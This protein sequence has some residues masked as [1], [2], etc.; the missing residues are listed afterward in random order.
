MSSAKYCPFCLGNQ[1]VLLTNVCSLCWGFNSAS[2]QIASRRQSW[3]KVY[4]FLSV[5]CNNH[6]KGIVFGISWSRKLARLLFFEYMK[7]YLFGSS[8][9]GWVHPN[10]E[11]IFKFKHKKSTAECIFL[12]INS[13]L[14]DQWTPFL[15]YMCKVW[16]GY[17]YLLKYHDMFRYQNPRQS[18]TRHNSWNVSWA[19]CTTLT[20]ICRYKETFRNHAI[21]LFCLMC[22]CSVFCTYVLPNDT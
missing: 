14:Q 7:Y 19:E 15:S 6:D 11:Q 5:R 1:C 20:S 9:R 18:K 10:N 17:S 2:W 12:G 8:N 21:P 4:R 3:T 13:I 16:Y 22:L